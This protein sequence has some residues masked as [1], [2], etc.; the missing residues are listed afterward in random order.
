VKRRDFIAASALLPLIGSSA[1]TAAPAAPKKKPAA[2]PAQKKPAPAPKKPV[3]PVEANEDRVAA[4]SL[5]EEP[6][7]RWRTYDLLT[8]IE[9]RQTAGTTRL[10]LPLA[11]FKDTPWQRALGHSWQGNFERAGIYRDPAAEMEVFTAEWK[12]GVLPQLALQSRVETQD[13][14]FDVTK[15]HC[16][17]ERGEILRRNLQ[18][19]ELMPINEKTREIAERIVGRVRDPLAQGKVLYDWVADRALRDP[20][21]PA[22]AAG[23]IDTPPALADALGRNAGHALLFVA[24]ARAIGLPAR[25]VFGLRCDYSKLLPSLGLL[26]ELNRAFHCRAEFYAPGYDWIPVNPAD[27]RQAVIAE[28]LSADDGKL[29]VLKKLLFGFWEMNWIGLNTALEVTPRDSS[30]KLL[31]FLATP[32][33]ETGAGPLDTADGERFSVSMQATRSEG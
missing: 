31:P 6:A 2:R 27:L 8:R 21:T 14:H 12:D 20:E 33:I 30:G 1:A 3:A 7:P 29:A 13:R 32:Y 4:A 18:S 22:L 19:T 9:V 24:L 16:A 17:P 11:M 26:G 15:K 28:K 25:P 5:P 23:G 10:W